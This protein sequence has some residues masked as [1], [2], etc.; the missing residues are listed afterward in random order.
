MHAAPPPGDAG[1]VAG[2]AAQGLTP[3]AIAALLADFHHWL[4]ALAALPAP[5]P[6]PEPPPAPDLHALLGQLT[7]LRHEV[8]LQ[9]RAARA[10]QEQTGEALRVL[11]DALEELRD[12]AAS[13]SQGADGPEQ[14]RP[15]LNTLADLYD[16][17]AQ[18]GREIGRTRDAVLP[19]LADAVATAETDEEPLEL[20]PCPAVPRW[21]RWLGARDA[22]AAWR[23]AA[24][25]H[26]A[27]RRERLAEAKRERLRLAR[28]GVQ[29]VRRSLES[30]IAGYGMSLQRLDRALAQQ[31]LVPIPTE[32]QPFDP[33]RMEVLEAVDDPAAV[34]GT[35]VEEVRRGYLWDGRVF[36]YALV[37]VAR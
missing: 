32:G 29:K 16:A 11:G 5:P 19:A 28:E 4:T 10:Q 13:V 14:L 35:V 26:L 8:N 30:L 23:D 31:G 25:K 20:P 1:G 18:A 9:T 12:T 3:A 37:R 21:Q 15:L 2:S 36:R 7:A 27:A 34:P 6:G 17:L 33:E 24:E 22:A